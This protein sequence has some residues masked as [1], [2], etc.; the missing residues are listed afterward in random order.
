MLQSVALTEKGHLAAAN[1]FILAIRKP[2]YLEWEG[3]PFAALIPHAFARLKL[4]LNV[5]VFVDAEAKTVRGFTAGKGGAE[6]TMPLAEGNF[7]NFDVIIPRDVAGKENVAQPYEPEL[8]LHLKKAIGSPNVMRLFA[9]EKGKPAVITH[10]GGTFQALGVIMPM[11]AD[12]QSDLG[13]RIADIL[14][15]VAPRTEAQRE[16]SDKESMAA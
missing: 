5:P 3:E 15:P 2:K 11:F 12:D 1:G 10:D 6:V 4:D 8:V 14:K 9:A 13:K 7:P 16:Q